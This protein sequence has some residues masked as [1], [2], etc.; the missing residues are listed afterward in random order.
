[1]KFYCEAKKS[2]YAIKTYKNQFGK[3]CF[4]EC[5]KIF[6]TMVKPILLFGSEIWGRQLVVDIEKV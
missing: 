4:N 2:V 1:M 6:D 3:F 5:F